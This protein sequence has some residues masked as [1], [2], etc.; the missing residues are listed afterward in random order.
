MKIFISHIKEESNLALVLKSWIESTFLGQVDVFVSSDIDDISA[1]DKW[2]N[3][4]E[5]SLSEA[6]A[7]IVICSQN[8]VARPWINFET[9]AGWIK[10]IPVIPVCHS[11]ITKS[12][13]PIPLSFFQAVAI[14]EDNFSLLFIES[15]AKHLG[16]NRIPNI[17]FDTMQRELLKTISFQSDETF[18]EEELG[19]I[20]YLVEM[21]DGFAKLTEVSVLISKET[22]KIGLETQKATAQVLEINAN[23]SQGSSK[24][25]QRIAKHLASAMESYANQVRIYNNEFSQLL[26][27]LEKSLEFI[28]RP[29][30][31][32]SDKDRDALV[33]AL[34]VLDQFKITATETK[35][36]TESYCSTLENMPKIER[37]LNRSMRLA[38]S[39]VKNTVDNLDNT[40]AM[41]IK[42]I[43]MANNIFNSSKESA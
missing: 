17:S 29:Q 5:Q 34:G 1:G 13:L 6:K 24:H 2:F 18:Q 32:T 10:K 38:S 12:N 22:E 11:G 35:S 19:L 14:T 37:H 4:I 27:R 40:V 36:A 26:I 31:I 15:L 33:F 23:P 16:Y 30:E 9:G 42:I 3:S 7:L 41:T 25:N 43:T 39:E 8:S 28:F 21:E 20:D